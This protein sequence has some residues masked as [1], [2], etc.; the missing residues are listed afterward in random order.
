MPSGML[1]ALAFCRTSSGKPS[2]REGSMAATRRVLVLD[3]Q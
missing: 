2:S 3:S 1:R